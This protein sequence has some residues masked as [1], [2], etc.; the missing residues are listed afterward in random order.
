M[1]IAVASHA[2]ERQP[3]LPLPV[4]PPAAPAATALLADARRGI[5][6][7]RHAAQPAPKFIAAYLAALRAGAA[8][9]A[10]RGR[11]HR[12]RARPASVWVLL[13]TAAPELTDW[14]AYF[15][16]HSAARAAAQAGNTRRV[17]A[18]RA[19]ELLRQAASFV[20]LARNLVHGREPVTRPGRARQCD[21]PPALGK[22]PRRR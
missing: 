11:P 4:R 1:S 13:E 17:T 5:A 6:E 20:E 9:L 19:E 18:E 12:G 8:V 10:A 2:E 3:A 16:A 22:A 21:A 7:A 15:A 14:T